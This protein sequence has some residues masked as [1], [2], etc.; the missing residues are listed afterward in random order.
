M[1]Y[2][3][4]MY[5]CIYVRTYVRTYVCIYDWPH[6]NSCTWAHDVQ[7]QIAGTNELKSAQQIKQGG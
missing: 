5:V 3:I 1:I 4:C 6:G 2:D 7:L